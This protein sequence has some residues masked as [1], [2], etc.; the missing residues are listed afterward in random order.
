MHFHFRW[1]HYAAGLVPLGL[2]ELSSLYHQWWWLS[3]GYPSWLAFSN[4]LAFLAFTM[5]AIVS[6]G[7]PLEDKYR[8]RVFLSGLALIVCIALA[9]ILGVLHVGVG[10]DQIQGL[11]I[12]TD[13]NRNPAIWTTA[14]LQGG[15]LSLVS[16]SMWSIVSKM[17]EK[18]WETERLRQQVL[19]DIDAVL[20]DTREQQGVRG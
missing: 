6:M 5:G 18:R 10:T 12:L 9:N 8:Q 7:L 19:T 16:I 14:V 20:K 15:L 11:S 17:L 13:I 2:I 4:A 1:W 3:W